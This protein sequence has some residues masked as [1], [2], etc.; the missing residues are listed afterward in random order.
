MPTRSK[1]NRTKVLPKTPVNLCYQNNCIDRL[2]RMVP[3]NSVT[4]NTARTST[5]KRYRIEMLFGKVVSK[6]GAQNIFEKSLLKHDGIDS[7]VNDK[8]DNGSQN[9]VKKPHSK[10]DS[11]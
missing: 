6:I 5:P 4:K 2:V 10:K 7:L 9:T 3:H 11:I 1:K 8:F